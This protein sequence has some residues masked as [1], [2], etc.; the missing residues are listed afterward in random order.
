MAL[1]PVLRPGFTLSDAQA[2]ASS[3]RGAEAIALAEAQASDAERPAI[4]LLL[5]NQAGDDDARWLSCVNRYVT[6]FGLT[7]LALRPEGPSRFLRLTAEVPRTIETGPLVSVVMCAYDAADTLAFAAD[8]ILRQTWR[9]LELII[10]DDASRDDTVAVA[11]DLMRRDDRV[12]L[13]RNGINVGCDVTKSIGASLARGAYLTSHDADDWAHPERIERQV[14]AM[15]EAGPAVKL[16]RASMLRV[17]HDGIFQRFISSRQSSPDG[18]L[19]PAM[20][21]CLFDTRFFRDKLGSWD[22]VRFGADT[23]MFYRAKAILGD[24]CRH[25][26]Q[27]AMLMLDVETS[28]SYDPDYGEYGPAPTW[29]RYRS[30]FGSWHES[31]TPDTARLPLPHSD[32]ERR[33]PAPWPIRVAAYR[34]ERALRGVEGDGPDAP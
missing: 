1:G 32:A 8:S 2:G 19:R 9:P 11:R 14:T 4:D 22:S 13:H 15:I 23:E 28:E 18:A 31:L 27:L 29:R 34:V 6:R 20:I 33:F 16:T 26:D 24:D 3:G 10:V 17:T 12:R 30:A 5:A 21:S 25:F 7:P